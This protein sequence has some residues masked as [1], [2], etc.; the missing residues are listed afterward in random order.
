MMQNSVF[1]L[2]YHIDQYALKRL[3]DMK[4]LPESAVPVLDGILAHNLMAFCVIV[5]STV[6]LLIHM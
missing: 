2:K 1:N 4:K 6:M 5:S 3:R